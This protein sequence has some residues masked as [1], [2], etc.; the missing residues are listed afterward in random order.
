[1]TRQ[2]GRIV[3]PEGA[4]MRATIALLAG[5]S[6]GVDIEASFYQ[7]RKVTSGKDAGVYV[8]CMPSLMPLEF[9]KLG[10]S[11]AALCLRANIDLG[12]RHLEV[13]YRG[14]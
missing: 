14:I 3:G 2:G 7:R 5:M 9:C 11:F 12:R 13:D 4:I 8:F 1:M 6:G 10:K